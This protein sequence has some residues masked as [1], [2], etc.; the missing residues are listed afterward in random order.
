MDDEE[1]T[2]FAQELLGCRSIGC[3]TPQEW[4]TDEEAPQEARASIPQLAP[5]RLAI[6]KIGTIRPN[7]PAA[8]WIIH[9]HALRSFV[10]ADMTVAPP[11]VC[12]C[13]CVCF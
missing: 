10:H 9:W 3:Q 13:Q 7:P 4:A 11:A 12:V 8:P 5:R 6:L 2:E 1:F